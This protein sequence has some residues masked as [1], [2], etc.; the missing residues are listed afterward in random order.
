MK[1]AST[2]ASQG[3][4]RFLSPLLPS[5]PS[6]TSFPHLLPSPPYNHH[7]QQKSPRLIPAVY[8]FRTIFNLPI[9]S[10]SRCYSSLCCTTDTTASKQGNPSFY[11]LIIG[12][13]TFL[14]YQT[15]AESH[16]TCPVSSRILGPHPVSRARMSPNSIASGPTPSPA[17]STKRD[18][19]N[20]VQDAAARG[21]AD[22]GQADRSQADRSQKRTRVRQACNRCKARKI[23]C[24]DLRPCKNCTSLGLVCRDWRPGEEPYEQNSLAH[25]AGRSS[26]ALTETPSAPWPSTDYHFRPHS[27]SDPQFDRASRHA[28]MDARAERSGSAIPW[29]NTPYER[30]HHTVAWPPKPDPKRHRYLAYPYVSLF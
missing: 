3:T 9:R 6:L 10:R 17:A 24:G 18:R 23:K 16:C 2:S 12:L 20:T 22:R 15:K 11:P 13:L 1:I 26:S 4:I 5:P 30:S 28:G 25:P 8:T 21:Q 19:S 27:N 7:H 29:P 14:N